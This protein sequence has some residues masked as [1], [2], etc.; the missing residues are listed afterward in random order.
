MDLQIKSPVDYTSMQ[1]KL[2]AN[3]VRQGGKV[4]HEGLETR[5]SH[6]KLLAFAHKGSK[7]IGVAALKNPDPHYREEVFNSTG[8]ELNPDRFAFELGWIFVKPSFR[9]GGVSK[10]MTTALMTR[11]TTQAIFVTVQSNN[12]PMIWVLSQLGFRQEGRAYRSRR[13][14]YPLVLFVSVPHRLRRNDEY[15]PQDADAIDRAL[16]PTYRSPHY[17]QRF[18]D[19]LCYDPHSGHETR[20]Y[21]QEAIIALEEALNPDH[22]IILHVGTGG[23]KTTIANDFLVKK[24]HQGQ[25][26]ILWI[27]KDW[28]LLDQAVS[29]LLRRHAHLK[30]KSIARLGGDG[31]LLHPLREVTQ[32]PGRV[33]YSTVQTAGKKGNLRTVFRTPKSRPK[34]VVYDE[35]HWGLRGKTGRLI[36]RW[37]ARYRIPMIGLT[38]TPHCPLE[39]DTYIAYSKTFAEL[40]A[41]GFLAEPKIERVETHIR[42]SPQKAGHDFAASSLRELANNQERNQQIV[43][44]YKDHELRYGKT[45]VFACNIAHANQLGNLFKAAGVAVGVVHSKMGYGMQEVVHNFRRGTLNVLVNVE[46]MIHGVDIPDI[47]TIFMCRP[48]ASEVLFSQM[49]GRGCR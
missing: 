38:A 49:I 18:F 26:P 14:P 37:C 48:T 31:T 7:L 23:G 22:P 42:W 10:A 16:N 40:V 24:M 43:Q 13:G 20:Y 39:T 27:A 28:P 11:V 34:L 32:G 12:I 45:L 44:R 8:S 25:R 9:R 2:F 5:I 41:E 21:Q 35:C 17:R 4:I 33:V 36:R 6:A 47:R 3:Q 29:D 19:R 1:L 15:A 46:Q 30:P